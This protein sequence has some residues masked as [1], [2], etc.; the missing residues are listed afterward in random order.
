MRFAQLGFHMRFEACPFCAASNHADK[1]W[2]LLEQLCGHVK[3]KLMILRHDNGIVGFGQF[4]FANQLEGVIRLRTVWAMVASMG[5][6]LEP[7]VTNETKAGL[8]QAATCW[9]T[10]PVPNIHSLGSGKIFSKKTCHARHSTLSSR[11]R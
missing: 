10:R 9:A 3:I 6:L 2:I 8:F 11:T 7:Q 4:C 1:P 5:M